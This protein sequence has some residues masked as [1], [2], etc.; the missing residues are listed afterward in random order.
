MKLCHEYIPEGKLC[1]EYIPEGT[2]WPKGLPRKTGQ[3]WDGQE[4]VHVAE[5]KSGTGLDVWF[6]KWFDEEDDNDRND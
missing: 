3:P 5:R 4:L 1:H 6:V 2:D